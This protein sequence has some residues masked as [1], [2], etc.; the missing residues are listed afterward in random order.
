MGQLDQPT[1][2]AAYNALK[3]RALAAI[4]TIVKKKTILGGFFG[5]NDTLDSDAGA[6]RTL[7][8]ID[9]TG[10]PTQYGTQRVDTIDRWQDAGYQA[11]D[12]DSL[13]PS[14]LATGKTIESSIAAIDGYSDGATLDSVVHFTA[15]A[16][17]QQLKDDANDALIAASG[18]VWSALPWWAIAGIGVAALGVGFVYVRPLLK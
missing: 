18:F 4:D 5:N 12:D 8:G 2:D 16:T 6:I 10:A 13:V 7:I 17:S 15:Q 3:S 1:V 11:V 9:D 14:W